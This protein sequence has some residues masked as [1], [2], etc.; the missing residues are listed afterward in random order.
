MFE[1]SYSAVICLQNK[2]KNKNIQHETRWSKIPINI[3]KTEKNIM[4]QRTS[5]TKTIVFH[6]TQSRLAK[7]IK[8]WHRP[9]ITSY[10]FYRF[11][12]FLSP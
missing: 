9:M 7:T 1:L 8:F 12:G 4:C 11:A 6:M 2:N 10:R 3:N 5:F